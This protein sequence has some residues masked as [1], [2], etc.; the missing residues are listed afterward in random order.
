MNGVV[1]LAATMGRGAKLRNTWFKSEANSA[2]MKTRLKAMDDYL[3]K[4]C[5]LLTFVVKGVNHRVDEA[6]VEQDDFAQVINTNYISSGTR[7]FILPSFPTQAFDEQV[8]TVCHELSHRI[9]QTTDWPSGNQCYG[10]AEAMALSG[11]DAIICAE[12]WG[13]FYMDLAKER[14]LLK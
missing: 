13:Y 11:P 1:A 6:D 5:T 2:G 4:R 10:R 14:G 9:L 7:I 12:N 8:N 3:T